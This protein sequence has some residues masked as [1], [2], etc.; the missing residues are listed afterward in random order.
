MLNETALL[1]IACLISNAP[2]SD[3]AVMLKD[4]TQEEFIA[5]REKERLCVPYRLKQ[6]LKKGREQAVRGFADDGR[7]ETNPTMRC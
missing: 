2:A 1:G 3:R 7:R 5:V 4:L 6:I